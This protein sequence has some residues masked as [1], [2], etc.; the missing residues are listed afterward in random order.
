MKLEDL[1]QLEAGTYAAVKPVGGTVGLLAQW[2]QHSGIPAANLEAIE[3]LHVT[4]LYSR[5]PVRVVCTGQEFHATPA[6]WDLFKN[7]DGSVSLVLLLDSP[8]LV[9]RHSELM[10]LGATYDYPSYKPHL[11]V[12]YHF[13]EKTTDH[14]P[15]IEFGLTFGKEY[16]E[17]LHP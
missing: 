8:E 12:T 15:P 9:R 5:K 7:K 2:M 10:A 13:N 11:T 14:L 16:S 4:L 1:L 6:G 17:A 3:D